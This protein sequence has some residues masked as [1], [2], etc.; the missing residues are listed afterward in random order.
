[1]R[2]LIAGCGYVGMNLAGRLAAAGH[3]VW[4]GRRRPEGL[5]P[6]VIPWPLDLTRREL[7]VPPGVTHLV[8]AAAPDEGSEEAYRRIYL[9][10]LTHALGALRAAGAPLERVVFVS[11]TS[12]FA[13]Q[14][15]GDVD[16]DSPTAT[17]G[18]SALLLEAE[19]LAL[20]HPGGIV[21]R[22]SGIYGP[23]RERMIR[24]V[25]EGAARR[26]TPSPIGN[27]IHRDDAAAMIEHLLH[28]PDPA[29]CYLGVDDAPV[30]LSEVY[31]W[32]AERLDV[33][34]PPL[35]SEPDA[36]GRGAFKRCLN[37][38]LK[39]SGY[40]FLFPTYREGYGAML[41]GI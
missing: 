14:S 2:V 33:P 12:V 41:Q 23:G 1:M 38:R 27:R 22:L 7:P 28:L 24:M 25:R 37:H 34:P 16:E 39:A 10:G 8:F 19:R 20:A 9:E 5:P 36:R 3:Q 13:E 6:G 17:D 35:S 32:L 29:R 15:G 11:S 4:A 26:A 31:E 40:R 21:A 30:P 18:K